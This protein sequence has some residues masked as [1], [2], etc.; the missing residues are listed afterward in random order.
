MLSEWLESPAIQERLRDFRWTAERLRELAGR[1]ASEISVT[2]AEALGAMRACRTNELPVALLRPFAKVPV[3]FLSTALVHMHGYNLRHVLQLAPLFAGDLIQAILVGEIGHRNVAAV[4]QDA[5]PRDG[6]PPLGLRQSLPDDSV[7]ANRRRASNAYSLALAL[8]IPYETIRRKLALLCRAGRLTRDS[9]GL[10]WVR[11][12][13][14][15]EFLAFNRVRRADMLAT[16]AA[17]DGLIR[18]G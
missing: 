9:N 11:P 10:F 16:A 14:A 5:A 4:T 2:L 17:I 15:D 6:D 18:S 7:E 3:Q 1:P 13:I 12:G 8:D